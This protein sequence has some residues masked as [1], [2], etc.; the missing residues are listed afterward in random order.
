MKVQRRLVKLDRAIVITFHLC[1]I[2]V[3]QHFPRASQGLLIHEPLWRGKP[4]K[5]KGTKVLRCA[6]AHLSGLPGWVEIRAKNG[7]NEEERSTY[8]KN[9]GKRESDPKSNLCDGTLRDLGGSRSALGAG[10]REARLREKVGRLELG[11]RCA[12]QIA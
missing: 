3:L 8:R 11:S 12:G 5:V 1:L 4:R 9:G 2:G 10:R 6:K 7:E